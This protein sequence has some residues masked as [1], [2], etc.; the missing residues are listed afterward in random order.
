[1]GAKRVDV[2]EGQVRRL[3]LERE[4]RVVVV[5]DRDLHGGHRPGEQRVDSL[6][7]RASSPSSDRRRFGRPSWSRTPY[8]CCSVP[9]AGRAPAK[10]ETTSAPWPI[11][12]Y[13]CSRIWPRRGVRIVSHPRG[14]TCCSIT[15]NGASF[16]PRIASQLRAGSSQPPLELRSG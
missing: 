2:T 12:W 5:D 4:A 1:M 7:P 14:P 15:Q 16:S 10:Y 11:I 13:V 8:Q 3:E 6:E 9:E